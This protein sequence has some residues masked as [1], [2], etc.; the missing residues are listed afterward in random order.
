MQTYG[1][2]QCNPCGKGHRNDHQQE[3]I[4]HGLQKIRVMQ[5]IGIIVG[6]HPEISLRSGIVAFLKGIYKHID[7]GIYHKY[8]QKQNRRHQIQPGFQIAVVRFFSHVSLLVSRYGFFYRV[9]VPFSSSGI[10]T[11]DT[12]I[13]CCVSLSN[14]NTFR[15]S[16]PNLTIGLPAADACPGSVPR[17]CSMEN[18]HSVEEGLSLEE[19]PSLEE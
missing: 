8:P 7:Q 19:W 13:R 2:Q 10:V 1:N 3:G 18:D 14:R 17:P 5:N 9:C 4:F 16:R 11:S 15:G 12:A 6:T